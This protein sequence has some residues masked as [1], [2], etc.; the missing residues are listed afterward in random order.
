MVSIIE[1]NKNK[2]ICFH[3]LVAYNFSDDIIKCIENKI[4]TKLVMVRFYKIPKM[5]IKT[6][7]PVTTAGYYRLLIPDLLSNLNQ[8]L[9]IDDDIICKGD[10]APL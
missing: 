2:N 1:N 6:V 5:K 4:S 3:L 9:Y 7:G 8:V 10:I